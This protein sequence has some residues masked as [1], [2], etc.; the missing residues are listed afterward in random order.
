MIYYL[1]KYN[2][3]FYFLFSNLKVYFNNQYESEQYKFE[4]GKVILVIGYDETSTAILALSSCAGTRKAELFRNLV[5][6]EL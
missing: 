5:R 6:S 4:K 2:L 3:L 1:N